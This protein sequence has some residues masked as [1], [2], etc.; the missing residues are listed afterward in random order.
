M[1][2]IISP[3]EGKTLVEKIRI[4]KRGAD[5]VRGYYDT[6][7]DRLD[8]VVERR[9]LGFRI[10][11][12]VETTLTHIQQNSPVEVAAQKYLGHLLFPSI[13]EE[14]KFYHLVY[15][16]FTYGMID[17]D[18]LRMIKDELNSR[19]RSLH[20]L[21]SDGGTFTSTQMFG[22]S[23][24]VG[25]L[26]G[27]VGVIEQ[28]FKDERGVGKP[29]LYS[30]ASFLLAYWLHRYIERRQAIRRVHVGSAEEFFE[31]LYR[32]INYQRAVSR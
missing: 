11:Y 15:G 7:N 1:L 17:S 3:E 9:G 28:S 6:E 12:R 4:G 18:G 19:L 25:G 16:Y 14:E 31:E 5:F 23:L 21:R 8:M 30:A 26:G 2:S 22:S 32:K 13:S 27:L 24:L 10:R 20:S 29:L